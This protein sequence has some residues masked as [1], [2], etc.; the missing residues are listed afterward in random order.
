MAS[1]NKAAG[2][3]KFNLNLNST[4]MNSQLSSI[5]G[6]IR[7]TTHEWI[8]MSS[9]LRANGDAQEALKVK[10]DGLAKA[11]TEQKNLL[12]QIAIVEKNSAGLIDIDS[13]KTNRLAGEKLKATTSLTRM[14]AELERT[15]RVM[16]LHSAQ[17]QEVEQRT[18]AVTDFSEKHI[19]RLKAEGKEYAAEQAAIHGYGDEIVAVQKKITAQRDS[20]TQY[21]KSMASAG[22][23]VDADPE[24]IKRKAQIEGEKTQLAQLKSKL[25]DYKS[26]VKQTNEVN[27]TYENGTKALIERLKAERGEFSAG[28]AE[29]RRLQT[30]VK[31]DTAS[32][33]AQV[34]KM[35]AVAKQSGITSR[36][37][38]DEQSKLNKLGTQ[39][40]QHAT[41]LKKVQKQ[42]GNLSS[43]SAK[44]IDNLRKSATKY[45]DFG[46]KMF[47]ATSKL[48]MAAG[49]VL[50][51]TYS[52]A[53]IAS[54]LQDSYV[55]TNNLL[56]TGG[57]KQAE[58]TKNVA[59]MQR[60]GRKDSIEYGESMKG[61]ADGYQE[62]TKRGYTSKQSLGSM[63]SILEASVASGDK[64]KDVMSVTAQTLEGFNM[65]TDNTKEMIKRT[66]KVVN[67]LAYASD[68][69]ASSFSSTGIAMSY[70]GNSAQQAGFS[71]SETASAIGVLSNNSLEA[72]QK[73]AA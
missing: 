8:N 67:E 9:G 54:D 37:Y 32:Y 73:L 14:Q 11:I 15:N 34:E 26:G 60:N 48:K 71:L 36:S 29:R 44:S 28:V 38:Q 62:L 35:K 63:K 47:S 39:Y 51:A 66:K 55:K 5:K 59:Q 53:K 23:S 64:Y 22:K 27:K 69:T 24:Y 43:K 33:N 25:L 31:L 18:K 3:L 58:V 7:E 20:L 1:G 10:S 12:E 46:S 40:N 61:I 17:L 68:M 49:G 30:Q 21:R 42:Y 16:T 56:V 41:Q 6:L 57:E 65:R 72:K 2:E 70:V 4:G 45:N 50:A 13:T 52:G 19:A